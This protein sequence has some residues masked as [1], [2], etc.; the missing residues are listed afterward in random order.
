MSPGPWSRYCK[1][2]IGSKA[3]RF[4]DIPFSDAG[5][6]TDDTTIVGEDVCSPSK[7]CTNKD[8]APESHLCVAKLIPQSV[9]LHSMTCTHVNGLL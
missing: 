5:R 3:A 7:S 1:R 6:G 2:V 8:L 9:C 4:L